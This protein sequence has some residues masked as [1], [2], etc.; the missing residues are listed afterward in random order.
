MRTPSIRSFVLSLSIVVF[1]ALPAEAQLHL[2]GFQGDLASSADRFLAIDLNGDKITDFIYYRPGG[3]Y[4]E[5][6]ISHGDGTFRY[7]PYA[8]PGKQFNGF[9]S[10]AADSRD[11]A[12]ALD[13]NGDG[14]QDFLWYRPG[15]Q[16]AVIYISQG[17]GQ[18]TP[19][20]LSHPGEQLHGFT[21]YTSDDRDTAVPLDIDGDGLED[22]LWFRPGS[23]FADIFLSNRNGTVQQVNL[24][25]GGTKWNG[26]IDD[27][28]T[29]KERALA[30]DLNGD[31]KSDFLWYAPGAGFARAYI[32]LGGGRVQ[33][34]AY[35]QPGQQ[36]FSGFG[37]DV[38]DERTRFLALDSNG[39]HKSDLLWYQPGT[40]NAS[41]YLSNGD[42]SL[43]GVGY[44]SFGR[45]ANGFTSD[46][47]DERDTAAVLDLN[48]DGRDD[49]LWYAPGG[50]YATAFL[51]TGTDGKVAPLP[52]LSSYQKLPGFDADLADV[53]DTIQAANWTG[54]PGSGFILYRPGGGVFQGYSALHQSS[55][56]NAYSVD[57]FSYFGQIETWMSDLS[58]V[59]GKTLV[60]AIAM[61]GT[62]DPAMYVSS[63][64]DADLAKTQRLDLYSQMK[65]GARWFDMRLAR[66]T[67]NPFPPLL[68]P[69]RTGFLPNH[70]FAIGVFGQFVHTD[71]DGMYLYGHSNLAVEISVADGFKQIHDFLI[72]HPKEIVILQMTAQV[73][74]VLGDW[75]GDLAK[76]LQQGF[77]PLLYRYDPTAQADRFP[78]N[79]TLEDLWKAGTRVI[80]LNKS[81]DLANLAGT[82]LVWPLNTTELDAGYQDSTNGI[83]NIADQLKLMTNDTAAD[84]PSFQ[85][86]VDPTV[87]AAENQISP[88]WLFELG[89]TLTPYASTPC[90]NMCGFGPIPLA[91][92]FNPQLA[93]MLRSPAWK[94]S[95]LNIV[96]IDDIGESDEPAAS[97]IAFNDQQWM[98]HDGSASDVA[99][100]TNGA[101]WAVG[102]DN[103]IYRRNENSDKWTDIGGRA[104][105]I[106]VDP[107]GTPWIVNSSHAIYRYD[108]ANWD[109]MPG[110]A[111]DIAI[112]ANGTVWAIDPIGA[113]L[114]WS[115]RAWINVPGAGTRI[116]VDPAGKPWVV[117][118]D[119]W[120]FRFNPAARGDWDRIAGTASDI[121]IGGDGTVWVIGDVT[122]RNAINGGL[123]RFNNG[124]WEP[125]RMSGIGVA[126]GVGGSPWVVRDG[127]A[128]YSGMVQ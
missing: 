20:E 34:V 118:K 59:I 114:L 107:K 75:S 111:S 42:G 74:G 128:L 92:A 70:T 44:S 27:V 55:P 125:F 28:S 45:Q 37:G 108:G 79:Q 58:Y 104:E 81:N 122:G 71:L 22:V 117:N 120:I 94:R 29:G 103:H 62:H 112:G 41:L 48:G 31:G 54:R 123:W 3:K 10:D 66:F 13:F 89:G 21:R 36:H 60:K 33:A 84:R 47:M 15:G 86:V 77:G 57:E 18:L 43:R 56:G 109:L 9:T 113:I 46:V 19:I 101:V 65:A 99:V 91:R 7:V 82:N 5:G 83:A 68:Q 97:I 26:F 30:L 72:D 64:S 124:T 32:S 2:R 14:K 23:G 85:P 38:S 25:G 93:G 115:G 90:Y 24:S 61:P 116:A 73:K 39:D 100:G 69:Y 51:S 96:S 98:E 78:Q 50:G 88:D 16:V 67:R 110:A 49:I 95:V 6:Y 12:V 8:V 4:V 121:A 35:A 40:G 119:G 87:D 52:L 1:V 127:G 102:T 76:L 11:T 63:M 80:V 106:A 17:D 53:R 126:A 105:R